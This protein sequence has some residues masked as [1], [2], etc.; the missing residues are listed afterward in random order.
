MER[1][2]QLTYLVT[3]AVA[4]PVVEAARITVVVSPGACI[5]NTASACTTHPPHYTPLHTTHPSTIH[6]PHYS[7]LHT[8]HPST[9]HTPPHYTPLP[10]TPGMLGF[11]WSPAPP[12]IAAGSLAVPSIPVTHGVVASLVTVVVSDPVWRTAF[13]AVGHRPGEVDLRSQNHTT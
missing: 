3:V 7:P 9:L 10:L 2:E 13:G 5:H 1:R 4:Q 12:A 6:P 8:T 11:P